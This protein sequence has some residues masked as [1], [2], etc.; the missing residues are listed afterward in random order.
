MCGNRWTRPA[1]G[2]LVFVLG[3]SPAFGQPIPP[4]VPNSSFEEGETAAAHWTLEGKG[5]WIK[6][7]AKNAAKHGERFIQTTSQQSAAGWQ[8]DIVTLLSE[9]DYRL[10]GWVRGADAR[11]RLGLDLLDDT[12]RVVGSIDAPKVRG[13]VEWRYVA[14]EFKAGAA[15]AR[16]RF[17]GEGTADLD[18]VALVAPRFASCMA[19]TVHARKSAAWRATRS[20]SIRSSRKKYPMGRWSLTSRARPRAPA[21]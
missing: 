21:R 10:D 12:G 15:R 11:A 20:K 2:L 16:I 13:A 3:S 18:D 17:T 14:V 1:I 6:G 8:S 4:L 7:V 19:A 9:T 5:A